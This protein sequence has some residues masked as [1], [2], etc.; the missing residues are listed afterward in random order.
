MAEGLEGLLERVFGKKSHRDYKR[1]L[2]LLERVKEVRVQYRELSD[3]QL[4]GMTDTFRQRLRDGETTDDL[5]PEA[6]GV[7]WEAC[8]RLKE[9]SAT[10]PVWNREQTWDMVPYDVQI[11]GAIVLHQGKIAEMATGGLFG[12]LRAVFGR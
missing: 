11:I 7:V 1:L 3:D 10:W 5:L 9:R 12:S 2:P 6:F 4:R 8:R